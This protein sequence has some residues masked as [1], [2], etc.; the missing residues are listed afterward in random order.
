MLKKSLTNN[1]PFD[2]LRVS[3]LYFPSQGVLPAQ[4]E[5]RGNLN[6]SK[7]LNVKNKK[8]TSNVKGIF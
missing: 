6:Q 4:E 5:P 7:K 2:K 8:F 3:G 1:T